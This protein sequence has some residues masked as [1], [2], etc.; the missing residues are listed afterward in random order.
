MSRRKHIPHAPCEQCN[1]EVVRR[2]GEAA[3][4]YR[5]RRTC[6]DACGRALAHATRYEAVRQRRARLIEEKRCE[7]CGGPMEPHAR[8]GT[9]A[10][11]KRRFCSVTCRSAHQSGQAQPLRLSRPRRRTEPQA[12]PPARRVEFQGFPDPRRPAVPVAARMQ[13]QFEVSYCPHHPREALT[14]FGHCPACR[15]RES[16][17][18]RQRVLRP[19]WEGR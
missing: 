8:E 4:H 10:F 7:E 17:V 14:I 12:A 19:S 11:A 9:D 5:K 16:W 15:A 18:E 3:S 13:P 6:S 1:G 2:P